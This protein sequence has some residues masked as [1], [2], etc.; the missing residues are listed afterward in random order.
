MSKNLKSCYYCKKE[1]SN[2]YITCPHCRQK[3]PKNVH[4]LFA[5]VAIVASLYFTVNMVVDDKQPN[6]VTSSADKT[7]SNSEKPTND[8]FL[9]CVKKPPKMAF[10]DYIRNIRGGVFLKEYKIEKDKGIIIYGDYKD[11]KKKQ[12]ESLMTENDYI[13]YMS[14]GDLINKTLHIEPIRILREFP[15]LNEVTMILPF[16]GKKYTIN[17]K[18]KSIEQYYNVDL[19]AMH[20]D[21][22]CDFKLWQEFLYKYDD[23]EERAKYVKQ[24]V[25]V[26]KLN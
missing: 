17:V 19:K 24:F 15:N 1:M 12:P 23:K 22:S 11:Y 4:P 14:T 8:D 3:Q 13:T 18:R 20:N 25:K 21:P 10:K 9:D 6:S 5:L 2:K 26:E 7:L 16:Q